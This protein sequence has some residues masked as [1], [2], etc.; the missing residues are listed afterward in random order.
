MHDRRPDPR[1]TAWCDAARSHLRAAARDLHGGELRWLRGHDADD[2]ER[3]CRA[4]AFGVRPG[5]EALWR[6]KRLPFATAPSRWRSPRGRPSEVVR[7]SDLQRALRALTPSISGGAQRRPLHAVVMR[8]HGSGRQQHDTA[9][10]IA[11]PTTCTSTTRPEL[12]RR[13][14]SLDS[15]HPRSSTC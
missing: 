4:G 14:P 6:G 5:S 10:C 15:W 2:Y 8:S 12:R 1:A 13:S 11:P 3:L 7:S 9:R